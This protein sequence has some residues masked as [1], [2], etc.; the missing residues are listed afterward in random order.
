MEGDAMS[1]SSGIFDGYES[2]FPHQ[3]V[4]PYARSITRQLFL[5]YSEIEEVSVAEEEAVNADLLEDSR[6]ESLGVDYVGSPDRAAPIED[7]QHDGDDG[8]VRDAEP[9][10]TL[11]SAEYAEQQQEEEKE[12]EEEE[13]DG[14]SFIDCRCRNNVYDGRSMICCDYCESWQ[15]QECVGLA[16]CDNADAIYLCLTCNF[17][18]IS[19]IQLQDELPEVY[20]STNNRLK[21]YVPA[22]RAEGRTDVYEHD[23]L[24]RAYRRRLWMV[25]GV[26]DGKS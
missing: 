26:M 25:H 9:A 21:K 7:F 11:P 20:D 23:L 13:D 4:N 18:V 19:L 5:S 22:W 8:A 24:V 17:K 10:T 15:H 14:A 6:S 2:Q 1:E 16:D 3:V 12:Q